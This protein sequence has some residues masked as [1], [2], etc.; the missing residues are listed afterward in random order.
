[1]YL[2]CCCKFCIYED[3]DEDRPHRHN[4]RLP[5]HNLDPWAHRFR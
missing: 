2:D 5:T 1:M 4:T 3:D